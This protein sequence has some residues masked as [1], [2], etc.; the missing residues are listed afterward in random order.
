MEQDL[1]QDIIT[2]GEEGNPYKLANLAGRIHAL[3]EFLV[4]P[5]YLFS[6]ARSNGNAQESHDEAD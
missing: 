6:E 1:V 3:K 5:E 2:A 4:L